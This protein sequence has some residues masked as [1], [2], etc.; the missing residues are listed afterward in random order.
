MRRIWVLAA[1]LACACSGSSAPPV[2]HPAAAQIVASFDAASPVGLAAADGKVWVVEAAGSKITGRSTPTS[3]PVTIRVGAT[4][5]RVVP[6]ERRRL[7]WVSVFGADQ[8]VAV[9]PRTAEVV[10]RVHVAGQPEG[11]VSAF[12]RV[13][14]VR[15]QAQRLTEITTSG[16]GRSFRLGE[17]PRL[18]AASDS[19][20][21]ASNFGAGTVTRVD[22]QS[23]KTATSEK[24]CTGPQDM[25]AIG[26]VLWVACTPDNKVVAVDAQTL[27]RL[28]KVSID[29]EPDAL[30]YDG[31]SLYVV[32][33]AGPTIVELNHDP[34]HP[35]ALHRKALGEAAPLFD[36]ANVDALRV[37]GKWWVSSPSENKV[38]VYPR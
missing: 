6:D 25:V 10:R 26:D 21:F 23:K 37:A 9:D 3:K 7:L 17:E 27:R 28:G 2:E 8:V 35:A 36:Q 4:P 34:Q 32:T 31:S 38:L 12:G 5:L 15:Q 29:G 19:A 1:V 18:V 22:P 20:L 13:W 33:T 30:F 16:V 14:V 24:L 11:L